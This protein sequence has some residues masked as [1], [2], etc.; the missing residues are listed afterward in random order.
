[1]VRAGRGGFYD[2]FR[3]F[4]AALQEKIGVFNTSSL[5]MVP[6]IPN[7]SHQ[8]TALLA[9]LAVLA[10]ST[11]PKFETESKDR[12]VMYK[13]TYFCNKR[14][15]D[16]DAGPRASMGRGLASGFIRWSMCYGSFGVFWTSLHK[17]LACSIQSPGARSGYLQTHRMFSQIVYC[18]APRQSA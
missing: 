5:K 15:L 8:R 4:G 11:C 14:L 3:V 9:L 16:C 18:I 13:V 7:A 12:H 17:R 6:K 10:Q 2:A 1:M